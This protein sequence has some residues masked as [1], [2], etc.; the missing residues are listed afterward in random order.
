MSTSDYR[1]GGA[2]KSALIA[3][4]VQGMPAPDKPSDEVEQLPADITNL[5]DSEL[6]RL[7]SQYTAWCTYAGVQ[8]ALAN[9]DEKRSRR[10]LES[11]E[12]QAMIRAMEKH[13][14]VTEAR[15]FAKAD[16]AIRTMYDQVEEL[17]AYHRLVESLF[18]GFERSCQLLSRELTRRT[19]SS[20][21]GRRER[22]TL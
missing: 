9:A 10:R 22:W 18:S 1:A 4:S 2:G 14:K 11:L 5:S 19:A 15:A 8:A 20:D 7:Y 6:M 3:A 21:M 16:P 13:D 12:A 17:E